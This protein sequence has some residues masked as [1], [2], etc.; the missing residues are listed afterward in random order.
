M[1]AI[2]SAGPAA[3]RPSGHREPTLGL[4][5]HP[6]GAPPAWCAGPQYVWEAKVD[7]QTPS[8][9]DFRENADRVQQHVAQF[10]TLIAIEAYT[11]IGSSTKNWFSCSIR[12]VGSGSSREWRI[13][14]AGG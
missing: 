8:G 2:G 1:T 13:W 3:D 11:N 4:P 9:Y 14:A 5:A 12:G 10:A 6:R 7:L